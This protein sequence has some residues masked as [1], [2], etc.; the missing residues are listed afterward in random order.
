MKVIIVYGLVHDYYSNNNDNNNN[1]NNNNKNNNNKNN[2]NNRGWCLGLLVVPL[3]LL[4]INIPNLMIC[5]H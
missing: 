2:K 5:V 1:N 4:N 3:L